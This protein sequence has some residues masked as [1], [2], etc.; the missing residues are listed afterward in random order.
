MSDR[1]AERFG[2]VYTDEELDEVAGRVHAL[3][4]QADEVR[5]FFN[6]NEGD[7][8]PTAARRMRQLLGQDPGPPPDAE[9]AQL[10]MG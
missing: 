9:H 3:A 7:L 6:N 4:E 8:A 2:W 1:V 5:V 10:R